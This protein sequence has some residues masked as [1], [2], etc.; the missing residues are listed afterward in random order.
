MLLKGLLSRPPM[1]LALPC[2]MVMSMP[3]SYLTSRQC[4]LT[5][6]LLLSSLLLDISTQSSGLTLP[7]L[8]HE[9]MPQGQAQAFISSQPCSLGIS[10]LN[11]ICILKTSKYKSPVPTF[12]KAPDFQQEEIWMCRHLLISPRGYLVSLLDRHLKLNHNQLKHNFLFSVPLT[13][14]ACFSL[15]LS[16]SSKFFILNSCPTPTSGQLAL[17]PVAVVQSLS[18]V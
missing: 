12:R 5:H 1:T 3:S 17:P 18:R 7:S 2:S 6:F 10:S 11:I 14:P 15:I 8:L 4:C 16:N 9:S 13:S